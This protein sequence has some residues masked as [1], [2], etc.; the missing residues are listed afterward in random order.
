MPKLGA[1]I[2]F[3]VGCYAMF[4]AIDKFGLASHSGVAKVVGREYREPGK[5]YV[6]QPIG[7]R[8]LT[9]AQMTPELYLLQ[10]SLAGQETLCAVD[11]STYESVEAGDEVKVQYRKRRLLGTLQVDDVQR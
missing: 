1:V 11:K 8:M 2:L 4:M 7:G 5:T 6:R 3:A 10:I 9:R